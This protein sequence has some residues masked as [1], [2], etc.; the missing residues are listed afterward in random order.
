MGWFFKSSV[1][2]LQSQD[3]KERLAAAEALRKEKDPDAVPAL[4]A[5]MRDPDSRV[6]IAAAQALQVI[7]DPAIGALA[8]ALKDPA[9]TVRWQA[10]LMLKHLKNRQALEP[11]VAALQDDYW[12]VRGTAALALG[13]IGDPRAYEP[14]AAAQQAEAARPRERLRIATGSDWTVN[15]VTEI[16]E[17]DIAAALAKLSELAGTPNPPPVQHDRLDL[18]VGLLAAIY[19]YCPDGFVRGQ[20]GA[21][22]KQIRRI[23]QDL[24]D[25][26]GM[27]LMLAA[28]AR[29]NG[30]CPIL[31]AARNLEF[32]WDGIG[33]WRG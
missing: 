16:A 14:L 2:K 4:A 25:E 19:T 32:M 29:F 10:A 13:D 15:D 30:I 22:E 7:G 1:Q 9:W 3:P 27:D 26:G 8:E 12:L 6:A 21:T 11:L 31:G 33:D 28:H 24:H 17:K 18:A 20:G 5:A 23:G